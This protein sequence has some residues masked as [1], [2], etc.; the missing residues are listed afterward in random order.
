MIYFNKPF[1]HPECLQYIQDT[2]YHQ[3]GDGKYSRLLYTLLEDRYH[4]SH[5]LLTTSCTHAL[6]MMGMIIKIQPGDEIIIPSYTFVSTANAFVRLGANVVF[7]DSCPDHPTMDIEQI[8]SLVTEK[9]KAVCIVHYAGVSCDM[10]RLQEICRAHNLFLLE[11]AA[12]AIH[13][14]YRGKPLGS[15]GIMSAFSFHETKNI[16]C[17]EGGLLVINDA[18]YVEEAEI[19][20]EKGTNR[21]QFQKKKICKYEWVRVGSSYVLSDINA[22][23]LYYQ[24]LHMDELF[25]HRKTL[26]LTYEKYLHQ[27]NPEGNYHIY[28]ILCDSPSELKELLLVQ[29]IMTA[30]HYV[31][32]HQSSYYRSH[33]P[34]IE[35]PRSEFFSHHL[36][37]LP[38]YHDLTVADVERICKV[39]LD[40]NITFCRP[41]WKVM[42]A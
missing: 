3:S 1:F 14:Y 5:A 20:R 8:P 23:Y 37:R 31:P 13:S 6:E 18:Q 33:Y 41:E 25:T 29:G 19:I 11:D 12:Q 9:T 17:G 26:W 2:A 30:T 4:F 27:Q 22:A 24:F 21:S 38:L 40:L 35:L 28:Y 39:I 36:L 42:S 16:N 10:D 7:A 15:F 32:L 34:E